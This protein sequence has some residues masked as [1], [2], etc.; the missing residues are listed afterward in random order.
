MAVR[1]SAALAGSCRTA[2]APTLMTPPTKYCAQGVPISVTAVNTRLGHVRL[3]SSALTSRGRSV[4]IVSTPRS[5]TNS[6]S[7][8]LSTVHT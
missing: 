8:G 7:S 2:N 6:T 3:S 5:S 4:M 1:T